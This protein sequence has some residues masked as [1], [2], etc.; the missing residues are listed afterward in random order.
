L[1]VLQ[2][3]TVR[4]LDSAHSKRRI[5]H[6]LPPDIRKGIDGGINFKFQEGEPNLKMERERSKTTLNQGKTPV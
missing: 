3:G 4:R 1:F 2:T 5:G 6:H